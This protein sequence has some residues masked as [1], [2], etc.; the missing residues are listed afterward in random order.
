MCSCLRVSLL[1]GEILCLFRHSFEEFQSS[2]ADVSA[3]R[4]D[5]G[6][7]DSSESVK[8]VVKYY[9]FWLCRK[10]RI[11]CGWNLGLEL[12]V[13]FGFNRADWFIKTVIGFKE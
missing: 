8:V 3:H 7:R 12:F 10:D 5:Y 13:W 9:T 2:L 6:Q 1:F 11:K 4:G